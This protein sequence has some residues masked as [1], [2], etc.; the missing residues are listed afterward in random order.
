MMSLSLIRITHPTN[1][2]RCPTYWEACP[3]P[4]GNEALLP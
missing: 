1:A 3:K 2:T 4:S